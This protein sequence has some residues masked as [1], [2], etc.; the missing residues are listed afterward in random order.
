MFGETM[1]KSPNS[2]PAP[3]RVVSPSDRKREQMSKGKCMGYTENVSPIDV[4]T[5]L[6]PLGKRLQ[7]PVVKVIMY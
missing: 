7:A 1:L 5:H 3:A 6:I 2:P 4:K